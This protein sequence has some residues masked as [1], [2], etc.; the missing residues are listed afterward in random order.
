MTLRGPL[1]LIPAALFGIVLGLSGLGGCWR[2]AH[3]LWG[4]P[5]AIG[6]II[7]AASTIVWVILIVLYVAKWISARPA[8]IA[9]L[10][11]PVQCCFVGLIGVATMLIANGVLPYS[12][13]LSAV[14]FAAGA[15]FTLG[16][17]LW[18]TGL[19]WRGAR[20]V[21]DS[22]AILYL[23]T[24]AGTFVT[25]IVASALGLPDWGALAFGAGFFSWLAIES[26]LLHRLY[27]GPILPAPLR[28]TLGIQLA[29]PAVGAVAYLAAS[30]SPP[31]GSPPDILVHAMLGYG[32]LQALLLLR[33]LPWLR[34]QPFAP[35]YWAFTFGATA[36]AAAPMIM[37]TRGDHGAIAIIA[38]VLFL[39]ANIV[40][41][42]IAVGTV[43]LIIEGRL[44]PKP[45]PLRPMP[46]AAS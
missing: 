45:A 26:V 6:E 42:L 39:A 19:L 22:T 5:A 38:P 12:R 10:G 30:G 3:R 25:G 23:P 32:L 46:I 17:A 8:A 37:L 34:E 33:M 2:L 28:P 36:L 20:D 43:K 9:E 7:I 41:G 31:G 44:L 29:P 40:V 4:L 16:F 1:P 14:I 24:V 13:P 18:R 35:S 27:T 21:S 11:H 15:L